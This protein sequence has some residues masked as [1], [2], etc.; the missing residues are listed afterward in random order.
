MD[1]LL[2]SVADSDVLCEVRSLRAEVRRPK[3]ED[4][5][6][7]FSANRIQSL[8]TTQSMDTK[9]KEKHMKQEIVK[10][11]GL[12][13]NLGTNVVG[14]LTL[15]ETVLGVV[16][17]PKLKVEVDLLALLTGNT[18]YQNGRLLL[19]DRRDSVRGLTQQGR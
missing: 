17:V 2:M 14:G 8:E 6:Y 9:Q 16:H 1:T 11:F 3:S 10:S 13:S 5:Q 12:L 19:S 7:T 15:L 18:A 4:K